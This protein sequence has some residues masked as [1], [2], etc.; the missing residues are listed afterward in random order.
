VN[1]GHHEAYRDFLDSIEAEKN[2]RQVPDVVRRNNF[3]HFYGSLYY[4]HL[5]RWASVFPKDQILLLRTRD[6]SENPTE[7]SSKLFAFLNLYDPGIPVKKYNT[8]AVPRNMK[9]ERFFI[10]RD[11]FLR[12]VIRK[13]TPG[14]IKRTVVGSG[15][16]DRLH[17]ANRREQGNQPISPEQ[18]SEARKYFIEDLQ[19]L[20][21]EF[22][23]DLIHS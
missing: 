4:E 20:K 21:Q 10:D 16:V 1:N 14:F 18:E 17:E 7:F 6:L 13:I 12:K 8:A 3:G 19:L 11:H 2:I 5:S 15:V 22:Q 23:V 9:L